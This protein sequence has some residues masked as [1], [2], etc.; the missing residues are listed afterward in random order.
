MSNPEEASTILAG[1]CLCGAVRYE[2]TGKP[3]FTAVCHCTHC[4]RQSGSMFSMVCAFPRRAFRL[5]Q[6]EVSTYTDKADSGNDIDR[7]FCPTCGSPVY[8]DPIPEKDFIF[9]KAGTLDDWQSMP[10]TMEAYRSR[11]PEWVLPFEGAVAFAEGP[12]SRPAGG[13]GAS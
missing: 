11:A 8:S 4:V 7:C 10:P 3:L 13:K 9:V 2:A 1:G 12:A 6:G 5:V